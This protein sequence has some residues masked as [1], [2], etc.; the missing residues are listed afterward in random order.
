MLS[1]RLWSLIILDPI[2]Y[3]TN[4]WI[5]DFTITS[6]SEMKFNM[7]NQNHI[8]GDRKK[9]WFEMILNEFEWFGM[10]HV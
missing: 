2:Y 4:D 10:N 3:G 8:S 6:K 1:K 5:D 9:G 7:K